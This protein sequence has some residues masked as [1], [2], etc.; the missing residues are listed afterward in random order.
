LAGSSSFLA[1]FV[2]GLFQYIMG[3]RAGFPTMVATQMI[4][5]AV[6]DALVAV[7]LYV[8]L[9]RLRLIPAPVV[10]SSVGGSG[11]E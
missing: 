6:L 3:P 5:G 4:P 11:P 7:A 10:E 2:F 9:V 1:Q 8:L